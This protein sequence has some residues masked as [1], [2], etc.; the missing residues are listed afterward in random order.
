MVDEHGRRGRGGPWQYTLALATIA[1]FICYADRSNISVAILDM[2]K[3]FGWGESDKGTVLGI[4]F[5]GVHF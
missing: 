5:L 3:Q 4:F 2:A 1:I